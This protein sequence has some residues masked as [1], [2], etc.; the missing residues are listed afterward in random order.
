[1]SKKIKVCKKCSGFDVKK[2]KDFVPE[3]KYK[4]GSIG[5]CKKKHSELSGK[6]YGILDGKLTVCDSKKDFFDKIEKLL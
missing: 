6:C 3:K 4:V 2:L 5:A 1:M